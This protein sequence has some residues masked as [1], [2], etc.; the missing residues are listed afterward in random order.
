MA[1]TDGAAAEATSP[2]AFLAGSE[3]GFAA[4]RWIC[5]RVPAAKVNVT[6]SQVSFRARR[7]FAWLWRPRMYLGA[8]GAEVVLSIA[9]PRRDPSPRWKKVVQPSPRTWMHHLELTHADELDMEIEQWLREAAAA[10]TA[11]SGNA[12]DP[13][14]MP[15]ATQARRNSA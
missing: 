14:R 15:P 6:K 9:L 5:E 11:A 10:T 7:A 8:R 3:L 1:A 2:E 12:A 13:A 4:Y